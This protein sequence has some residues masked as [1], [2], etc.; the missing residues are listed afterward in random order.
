MISLLEIFFTQ[1]HSYPSACSTDIML[2]YASLISNDLKSKISKYITK[3]LIDLFIRKLFFS[4]HSSALVPFSM[5]Y[6]HYATV[7]LTC[8]STPH[9]ATLCYSMPH[10]RSYPS[11]C[12]ADSMLQYA[13]LISIG[14]ISKISKNIT[15]ILI[16]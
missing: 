8:Y 14:S 16:D 4:R 9:C 2:E 6:R 10:Q 1:Q 11:V 7:C 5:L 3:I 15:K 13:S 12:S